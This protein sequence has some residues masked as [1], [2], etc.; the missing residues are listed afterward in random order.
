MNYSSRAMW[1][2]IF[3]SRVSEIFPQREA[4]FGTSWH[5][6]LDKIED[7]YREDQKRLSERNLDDYPEDFF[8]DEVHEMDTLRTNMRGALIV[9][10]WAKCEFMLKQLTSLCQHEIAYKKEVRFDFDSQSKFY[11]E[12][13]GIELVSIAHYATLN[14]L[15]N[16]N[17]S[18]KHS[19]GLYIPNE[20]K[21]WTIIPEPIASEWGIVLKE[22]IPYANIPIQKILS[23][24]NEFFSELVAVSKI[25]SSKRRPSQS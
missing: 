9:S 15:Q 17:N 3:G 18:F 22:R 14:A 8:A 13:L 19:D 24:C 6:W 11:K 25:E 2:G 4:F 16:L 7:A 5:F 21:S 10:I 12:Q 1:W 20:K 23:E